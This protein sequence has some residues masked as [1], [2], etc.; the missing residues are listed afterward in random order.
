AALA[1]DP[2]AVP[3]V[4]MHGPTLVAK[5]DPYAAIG[6]T[7]KPK[8]AVQDNSADQPFDPAKPVRRAIPVVPAPDGQVEVRRAQP[9]RPIDEAGNEP[10]LQNQPPA[11]LD[12][13]PDH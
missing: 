9:V 10:L 8:V 11:P 2:K 3:A 7:Y 4:V 12:F 13:G 1:I 6:S 5:D